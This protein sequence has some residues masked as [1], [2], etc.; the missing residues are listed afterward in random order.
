MKISLDEFNSR[1]E[2]AEE[3]VEVEDKSI[4]IC[5]STERKKK[6]TKKNSAS[7]APGTEIKLTY[8]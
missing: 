5:Q 6:I 1:L 8:K 4:K 3:K 2:T 7:V